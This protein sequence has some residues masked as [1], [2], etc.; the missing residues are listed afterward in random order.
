MGADAPV[1]ATVWSSMFSFEPFVNRILDRLKCL[2]PLRTSTSI[3]VTDLCASW[4][5]DDIYHV[6]RSLRHDERLGECWIN[7]NIYADRIYIDATLRK[8]YDTYDD[9]KYKK[10]LLFD[11]LFL[12]NTPRT[13]AYPKDFDARVG[14]LSDTDSH[15]GRYNTILILYFA[16]MGLILGGL[17]LVIDSFK[18]TESRIFEST[19]YTIG[20]IGILSVA[21]VVLLS[22]IF[23]VFSRIKRHIT[24]PLIERKSVIRACEAV[25]ARYADQYSAV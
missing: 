8:P 17:V 11:A 20:T 24:K 22:V 14:V 3:D 23:R 16:L 6:I 21:I 5:N 15:R 10:R 25:I 12:Q 4:T 19:V 2:P 1:V 13:L 9:T 7:V 18:G